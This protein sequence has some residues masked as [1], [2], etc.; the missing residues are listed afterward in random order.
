MLNY[1]LKVTE[2][3]LNTSF[4]VSK[5]HGPSTVLMPSGPKMC[6]QMHLLDV[7]HRFNFCSSNLK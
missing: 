4:P 6:V 1:I 5:V 3:D 2:Q 7:K